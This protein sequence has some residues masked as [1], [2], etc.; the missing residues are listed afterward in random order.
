MEYTGYGRVSKPTITLDIETIGTEDAD[1]IANIASTIT[2]PGNISKAET[3]AAWEREK[4]PALIEEAVKKTSFDGTFG[5]IICIGWAFDDEPAQAVC[6]HDECDV[7]NAFFDAMNT[8]ASQNN[9]SGSINAI[10]PVFVGHNVVAF[11]L[12]FLWQRCVINGI[13]PPSFIPFNAKPWDSVVADTMLL[14]SPERERRISLDKLCTALSVKTSKD[15]MDGSNVWQAYKDGKIAE[16]AKYCADDVR[17][18][19]DCYRR[20]TFAS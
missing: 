2:P 15:G 16:I 5:K 1:V 13:K 7:L 8:M 4:K 12:R 3:I 9:K 20:M 11:D 6:K 19:R 17:A 18:V 10:K 14:W